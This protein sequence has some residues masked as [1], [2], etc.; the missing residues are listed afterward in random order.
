MTKVATYIYLV[1]LFFFIGETS[2]AQTTIDIESVNKLDRVMVDGEPV[3]K[4]YDARLR[5]GDFT[6]VSDSAWQFLEKDEFRAFGNIQINTPTEIIWADSLT[7]FNVLEF[8]EL[9]GRVIIKQDSTLLFGNKVDFNFVTKVGNFLDDIRLED[10]ENGILTALS[11]VYFQNQDS[12]EF[13][14][15][16]Q[17]AD[18]AQYVEG[19]SLFLNRKSKFLRL[20]DNLLVIDST[21]NALLTGD[22]LE[23]DSTGR[24]YL[25]G[26]G[27]LR[28]TIVDSTSSDTTHIFAEEI[29]LIEGDS[30]TTIDAYT[31][32]NVWTEKF[33]SL[34]DTLLY[35]SETELFRL[36]GDPKAWNKNIQ[37]TGP[38]IFVQLDSSEV[39][40]LTSYP[41]PFAVQEDTIS[42]RFNQIIG[43]T[44]IAD[45]KDGDIS[46]ITVQPN[47]EVLYHIT[48]DQGEPD[49]AFES[50]SPKT[51]LVFENGDMVEAKMEK[52]Q[53]LFLPEY[54]E[55]A[56]RRLEG[57]VWTPELRP[58]KPSIYPQPTLPPIPIERPFPL[59]QRFLDFLDSEEY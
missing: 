3:R 52:N 58:I 31:E 5:T 57:F 2:F 27:Y 20:F 9:R 56:S 22:Y 16:V 21:N 49:G 1:G 4:L 50:T 10:N 51:I 43:D 39:Q 7:Y 54:T 8:S 41:E 53:G 38:Y 33:S 30:V 32:V 25:R 18:S 44:L 13:R 12:A 46:K 47:S 36:R 59:P 6:I 15:N 14:G 40:N 55:L 26:N 28:R 24:R 42:G 34:S 23:A 29:E 35:N 48:N 37:L 19:D 11:G 17:L 45:F